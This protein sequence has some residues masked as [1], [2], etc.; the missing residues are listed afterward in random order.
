MKVRIFKGKLKHCWLGQVLYLCCLHTPG[1]EQV[2][3]LASHQ[4]C[5]FS[6]KFVV[7]SSEQGSHFTHQ[8]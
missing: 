4:L 2:L 7:G 5:V 3:N 8:T 6:F 1:T